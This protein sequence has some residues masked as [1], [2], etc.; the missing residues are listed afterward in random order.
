[1]CGLVGSAGMQARGDIDWLLRAN[2]ALA[3]RG[4]DGQGLWWSTDKRVGLAHRRLAIID[5][6][7]LGHQPMHLTERGLT[8]AFNGEIYNFREL[9]AELKALGASFRSNSDTE[10]LLVAYAQWGVSCLERLNGM[11]S[12]ALYDD[13]TK[14]LLLARDRA[15]EKP[16]FYT[17]IDNTLY[18]SSELKGLMANSALPRKL[19]FSSLDHYLAYGYVPYDQCILDGYKKLPAAHAMRF[20]LNTGKAKVFRYW[21]PPDY[22]DNTGD[23]DEDSLLNDLENVLEEAVAR[24]MVADVPVGIL[25]SGGVDSSL[26]TAM[27][28][29][30]SSKVRTFSIGFPGNG[31]MDETQHARLVSRHFKTE[32]IEL[33]ADE[34]LVE[35]LPLL[36][37]Q[38]DEPMADSSMFPTYLVTKLVSEHCKVVLGGDGGDEL[39]GGYN[40]YDRLIWMRRVSDYVPLQL[41]E[42]ISFLARRL[43][44]EGVKGRNYLENL[45][46]DFVNGLPITRSLFSIKQRKKLLDHHSEYESEKKV[47]LLSRIPKRADLIQRATRFDFENYLVDDILV[48]VDR[49]SMQNSVE[50]RSPFLDAQMLDF[51]FRR[52][53]S[54]LKATAGSRKILLKRLGTR[55]LPKEFN[56]KRKQGFSIPLA[57]WLKRGPFR[58][59]FWETLTASDSMFDVKTLRNLLD[60]QDAGRHYGEQIFALVLFELWRKEY[61]IQF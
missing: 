30:R 8:I 14:E 45:D 29:R 21:E 35:L 23:I 24:Q 53:P 22:D 10:V 42:G 41:R 39:F 51:A 17:L 37:K 13:L 11:F 60:Q 54:S 55:I 44:P 36:A 43:I 3:H 9:R 20:C 31:S 27:A 28:S 12:F 25:L 1:M 16:M 34:T 48:K 58:N 6:T 38:F 49:A 2:D 57:A 7:P 47:V 4:P 40:S 18:F 52:V 32:H 5:L 15:G 59:L 50:V 46:A 19:D 26:V 33:G 61:G 56:S